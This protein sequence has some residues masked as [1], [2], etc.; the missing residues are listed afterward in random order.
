VTK[1]IWGE[2]YATNDIL[3]YDWLEDSQGRVCGVELHLEAEHPFS[4]WL[5]GWPYVHWRLDAVDRLR[6]ERRF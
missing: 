1:P 6:L 3:F 4:V 2:R 5:H